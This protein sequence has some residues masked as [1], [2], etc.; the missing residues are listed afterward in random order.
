MAD[1][2]RTPPHDD[3]A[4]R[5]ALGCVFIDNA[6]LADAEFSQLQPGAFYREGHRHIFRAMMCL[7]ERGATIDVITLADE[8][9]RRGVLDAVGGPSFL[10]RLSSTVPSVA[11]APAY[12]RIVLR[13]AIQRQ[14]IAEMTRATD[15]LYAGV[16]DDAA[17]R[18]TLR[19]RMDSLL[20]AETGA[21]SYAPLGD[22]VAQTFSELET[23]WRE[24]VHTLQTPWADLDAL[25]PGEGVGGEQLIILAARPG[26]GK[27]AVAI[28][29][30]LGVCEGV[31]RG[32]RKTQAP[33]GFLSLEMGKT[34]LARRMISNRSG[35]PLSKIAAL[36]LSE[37]EWGKVIRAG[38]HLS[39]LPLHIC[40]H[41]RMPLHV[42]CQTIRRMVHKDGVGLIVVDY[43]T[44]IRVEG[45]RGDV[46][47]DTTEISRSL[48]ALAKELQ[49]PII[50]LAQLNRDCESRADKR[51]LASDL[52][53][54]GSIEEDADLI[55][56]L[57]RDEVYEPDS[58]DAG[59]IELIARK[60]RDGQQGVARLQFNGAIQRVAELA[61]SW[62][63]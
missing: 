31:E 41:D 15:A 47:Q 36:R 13:D 18:D 32:G 44:R 25:L 11:N 26:M 6:V 10:S 28:E 49:I 45:S 46:R 21:D 52:K 19:G 7:H 20:R 56:A 55:L 38:S 42:V 17:W 54:S 30:A 57:Y 39:S 8:L 59:T 9:D 60:N 1:D 24:G 27:T 22:V 37:D 61:P 12:A 5:S 62:R 3:D 43:L 51:P 53:E 35:V 34:R 58:Q 16:R 33:V 23:Q 14:L 40:D 2:V 48:K 50:A 63:S 29:W 4:E